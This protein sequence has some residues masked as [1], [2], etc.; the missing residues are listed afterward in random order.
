M[1]NDDIYKSWR[2][3][4][5]AVAGE[6][7]CQPCTDGRKKQFNLNYDN[8]LLCG[9]RCERMEVILESARKIDEDLEKYSNKTE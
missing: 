4:L 8:P 5:L 7:I 1:R 2:D 9:C 6:Q 3:K